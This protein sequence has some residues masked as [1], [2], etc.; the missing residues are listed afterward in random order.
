MLAA[1]AGIFTHFLLAGN[2]N[3]IKLPATYWWYGIS[4]AIFAT[5]LPTFM[6]SNSMKR[7]G[8][9]NVAIISAIGPVSTIVQAH[10]VLGEPIFA[11]QIAGTLLVIAGVLLTGW[12][13]NRNLK[14]NQ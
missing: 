8:S 2:I 14:Q 12:K 3:S 13:S 5:V 11:L 10:F 4:L 9:N 6:M 1:T 7:I